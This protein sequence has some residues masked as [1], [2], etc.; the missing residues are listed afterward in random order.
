MWHQAQCQATA[1][2]LT[3]KFYVPTSLR[4]TQSPIFKYLQQYAIF[5]IQSK[6][7]TE[8]PGSYSVLL[9]ICPQGSPVKYWE[10]NFFYNWW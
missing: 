10:N 1:G 6:A 7:E 8:I 3:T 9:E 5:Y 2:Q 4:L